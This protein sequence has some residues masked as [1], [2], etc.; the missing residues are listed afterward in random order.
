MRWLLVKSFLKNTP[1]S[2]LSAALAHT[3]HHSLFEAMVNLELATDVS[4]ARNICYEAFKK[5][6]EYLKHEADLKNFLVKTAKHF[7]EMH[8]ESEQDI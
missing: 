1:N 8:I 7:S 2:E 4:D 5:S 6:P 3:D